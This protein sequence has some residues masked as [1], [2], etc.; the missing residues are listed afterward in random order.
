MVKVGVKLSVFTQFPAVCDLNRPY[1]IFVG[2][3]KKKREK[4][5]LPY[6][7]LISAIYGIH[8]GSEGSVRINK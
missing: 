1:V 7:N 3:L 6:S 2:D 8:V 5:D 4:K